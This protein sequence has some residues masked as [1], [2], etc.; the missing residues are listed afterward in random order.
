M[1]LTERSRYNFY[2][3]FLQACNLTHA[4]R[5]SSRGSHCCQVRVLQIKAIKQQKRTR[6]KGLG[7]MQ[8][9]IDE[10]LRCIDIQTHFT[11]TIFHTVIIANYTLKYVEQFTKDY[12]M[13]I[14]FLQRKKRKK[15]K[16]IYESRELSRR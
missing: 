11:I 7:M 9:A 13:G 4:T 5:T 2:A 3:S 16:Q 8:T 6:Q 15:K 12:A 14:I 1:P 10:L